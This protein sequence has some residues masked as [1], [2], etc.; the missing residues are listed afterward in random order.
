MWAGT[1][2]SARRMHILAF[3]ILIFHSKT[4][5]EEAGLMFLK[6]AIVSQQSVEHKRK[7]NQ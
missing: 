2:P 5:S 4:A 1:V 7:I 3:A 6:F